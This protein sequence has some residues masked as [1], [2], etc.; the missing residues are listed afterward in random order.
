MKFTQSEILEIL[1]FVQ[2][3]DQFL[4]VAEKVTEVVG[5]FSPF[6]YGLMEKMVLGSVDLTTA[7]YKRY[8]DN[9]F[10]SEEAMLLTLN[11]KESLRLAVDKLNGG[12]R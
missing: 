8:M 5:K 11:S 4:P 1:E 3:A 12:G 10:S 7:C 2:E 6:I 9:G